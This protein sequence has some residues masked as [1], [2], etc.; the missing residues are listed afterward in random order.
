MLTSTCEVWYMPPKNSKNILCS[1]TKTF[2]N[3]HSSFTNITFLSKLYFRYPLKITYGDTFNDKL[4]S[5]LS[6]LL[7]KSRFTCTL[8]NYI[9]FLLSY[10]SGRPWS[11][12][13][14]IANLSCIK[15]KVL[16]PKMVNGTV[17]KSQSRW[18]A[19]SLRLIRYS[20]FM[21]LMYESLQ[22]NVAYIGT[23]FIQES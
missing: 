4:R 18:N 11:Q 14:H 1:L 17:S 23:H 16:W 21:T 19:Y 12:H 10:N 5:F 8:A 9:T 20:S 22:Q 7:F 3:L 15:V 6:T 2:E 13:K